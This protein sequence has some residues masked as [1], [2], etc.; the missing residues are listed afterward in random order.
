MK[1]MVL[2]R[3]HLIEFDEFLGQM[4]LVVETVLRDNCLPVDVTAV[5]DVVRQL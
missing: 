2:C 5:R 1:Q 4:R 3:I